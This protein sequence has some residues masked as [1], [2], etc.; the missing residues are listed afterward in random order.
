M[1]KEGDNVKKLI[2]SIM[3]MIFLSTAQSVQAFQIQDNQVVPSNKVW[4]INFTDQVGFDSLTKQSI[5]VTDS[6]GNNA[7]VTLSLGQDGK[8]IIVSPPSGGYKA[9][10][11]YTLTVEKQAHSEG[12]VQMQQDRSIHFSIQSGVIISS[13]QNLSATINQGDS[14]QLPS[15]VKA[16]MSDGT[17]KY[18]NVTWDKQ[19]DTSVAGNF[20]YSGIVD[21]YSSKVTYD[22]TVIQQYTPKQIFDNNS[23]A[24]VYITVYDSSGTET[25]QGS[26]FI[27]SSDGEVVTNYHVIQGAYSAKVTLSDATTTYD[28]AG[29]LGYTSNG[30]MA[31]L[32]LDNASNLPTVTLG[33]SSTVAIGDE[34]TAIGSP[35]GYQNTLSS[36]LISGIRTSD[37]RSGYTDI[38]TDTPITHGSSGG[39]LFNSYGEVIGITYSG[40]DA[41]GDLNFAIP[42]NDLK[43]LL[44]V[45]TLTP[46]YQT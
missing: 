10:D 42:I 21:G 37:T 11:S 24:V 38:Q 23:A 13:I 15:T 43:S 17:V 40:V 7:N 34:V 9:G 20:V 8:S 44:N 33:D 1:M 6:E 18:V 22:L 25:A 36:G 3:L 28:V 4:T 32:K 2:F 39:A 35:E 41:A 46:I 16:E 27:I 12:N 30:D 45:T 19:A 26:G 14:Y 31:I 5:I 29:V